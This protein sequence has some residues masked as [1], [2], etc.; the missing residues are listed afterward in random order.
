[1]IERM[2]PPRS[3]T[4]EPASLMRAD[5]AQT[6]AMPATDFAVPT[7]E[8][9]N[10]QGETGG[11]GYH[12]GEMSVQAPARYTIS[13]PGDALEN[14]A[15]RV[16]GEVMGMPTS[17]LSSLAI[18]AVAP[19]QTNAADVARA[20]GD[21]PQSGTE[22][23]PLVDDVLQADGQPLHSSVRSFMEPRF[24]RTFGDVR[25]HTDSR[26]AE[27]ARAVNAFAYTVGNDVVFGNGQYMPETDAGAHLIAHE[28]THVAQQEASPT[29]PGM[30][31]MMQRA[32]EK[33]MKPGWGNTILSDDSWM[34]FDPSGSVAPDGGKAVPISFPVGARQQEVTLPEGTTGGSVFMNVK[35]E[36]F[37]NAWDGNMSGSGEAV[38]SVPFK[39]NPDNKIDWTAPQVGA[40]S[41]GYGAMLVSPVGATA[42]ADTV[43]VSPVINGMGTIGTSKSTG[44]GVSVGVSASG[45]TG[46]SASSPAGGIES[47]SYM[48][49][50]NV[51]PIPL[52]TRTF[53]VYFKV[54]SAAVE[55]KSETDLVVWYKGLPQPMVK[56]VEDGITEVLFVGH[57]STTNTISYNRNLSEQRALKVEK[58]LGTYTGSKAKLV[59]RAESYTDA[60]QFDPTTGGK[61]E[62]ED[63]TERFV[64][65]TIAYLNK[66][67]SP[68]IA[69]PGGAKP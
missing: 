28:L 21:A 66:P 7:T 31:R 58:I 40:T 52:E 19:V 4:P 54:N 27:S 20:E 33:I 18:S 68:P 13:Q 67:G 47:R 48:V 34:Q 45:T 23:S 22:V 1:M 46:T 5:T 30:S 44:G 35:T 10:A 63:E 32:V 24:G 53:P 12:I 50:L 42:T 17:S 8:S 39:I 60:P 16:A 57:A 64:T 6:A 14:E 55:D 41:V 38:L 29:T 2:M 11:S 62:V 56:S 26:A 3:K 59:H 37:R 65:V 25:I 61:T 36:W 51:A 49:K 43:T 15:T 9:A 69:P